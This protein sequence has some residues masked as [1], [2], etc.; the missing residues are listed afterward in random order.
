MS[1]CGNSE[2][3]DGNKAHEEPVADKKRGDDGP[4]GARTRPQVQHRAG[5]VAERD[6]L[7]DSGNAPGCEMVVGEG[8]DEQ[9]DGEDDGGAAQNVRQEAEA[10]RICGQGVDSRGEGKGQRNAGDE[11]EKR[12]DQVGEGPAIPGRVLQLGEGADAAGVDDDHQQDGKAAKYVERDQ[13]LGFRAAEDGLSCAHGRDYSGWR[14]RTAREWQEQSQLPHVS[15]KKAN[16]GHPGH[17]GISTSDNAIC[18]SDRSRGRAV[19][20]CGA[21]VR[22]EP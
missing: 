21:G 10:R 3:G 17:R 2:A 11:E 1:T 14:G 13:A 7:Q 20:R 15:Q 4:A 18:R 8:V 12:E 6:A 9:A 5:K 19:R 22:R 16:M